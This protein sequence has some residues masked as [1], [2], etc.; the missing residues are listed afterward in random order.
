V[1]RFAGGFAAAIWYMRKTSK[2]TD[3][4]TDAATRAATFDATFDATYAATDAATYAATRAAI[5]AATDDATYAATRAATDDATEAAIYAATDDATYAATRA[6]TLAATRAATFD[7]TFDATYAATDAATRAA[8]FDATLAATVDATLAATLAAT[9]AA[10][11]AA[12]YAATEAATVDATVDATRAATL[13]ATRA[14]TVDATFDATLAATVDAT[15]DATLAATV[16]A[17][18]DATLA[19]TVDATEAATRK[20]NSW[21]N[22]D[23]ATMASLANKLSVGAFGLQCAANAW[24]MYQGGNFWSAWDSLITFFRYVVKLG[25]T[26]GV[27]YSKYDHWEKASLHSSWRIMHPEFCIISDRPCKLTVDSEN[28]P[29]AVEGAFCEWRDGSKLYSIHGVRMPEWVCE[30]PSENLDAEK[31]MAIT[32][33][34]QRL[35]AIKKIGIE[36]VLKKLNSR[37]ISEGKLD[38]SDLVYKLHE[39]ELQGSKEKLFQMQNPSEQKEHFEWVV[40]E[41]NTIF[42]ADLWRR[43]Y[44]NFRTMKYEPTN[45]RA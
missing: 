33:V 42:E 35:M 24:R 22:L 40:P 11:Y 7:A 25:D 4:A 21:F 44:D 39:V 23:V 1:A 3:A 16:D 15:V 17:T 5:Y 29:H 13:A 6:A 43:G 30:T 10:T 37:V 19:A 12:T 9:D 32:N 26:H 36:R 34:E 28:R 45:L 20:G 14:A 8:T 2:A 18:V 41:C 38:S 31:V 27:D